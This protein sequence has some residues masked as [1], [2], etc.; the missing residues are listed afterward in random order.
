MPTDRPKF[1]L[2]TAIDYPNSRP[3]IGT[4]FEKIGADVQARYR[5]MQGYDVFFLMGNDENTVKVAKKA[6]ELGQDTQAYCDDMAR[7]FR[8]VWDALDISYDIFIQTSSPRHH[9]CCRKFIQKVYDNGYI[10]KDKYEGW[11]CVGCEAFKT[12]QEIKEAGGVCPNHKTSP[13]R[14]SEECYFFEQTKF[15]ERLL[16]LYKERPE[17]IQPE[18]RR[19]EIISLVKEG[20][21]D[22][23]ITRTGEEW[24]IRVPWDPK[25]TIYVWFDALLTY[26]TGI[27]YGDDEAEFR[28][29]WPCD[30]H[31]IGKDITRF[32]CATWPAMLLAAGVE[33]PKQVF[34]HGFV[35]IKNEE[36]GA[37]EKIS[38]SLGNVVEPMEIISKFSGEAFRYYFMRECPFPGDGEFSWQRFADVY[39]SELANNLGN[40][41]SRVV[42]L[43]SKNFGGT[44]PG[45]RKIDPDAILP[46]YQADLEGNRAS[47]DGSEALALIHPG[48]TANVIANLK[49]L[50]EQ[51]RYNQALQTI[52]A[53]FLTPANRFAEVTEPW[54]LVKTNKGNAAEVLKYMLVPLRTVSILLKPFVPRAAE[55]IYRSFNFT[56]PWEHVQYEDAAAYETQGDDLRILAQLEGGKVK[57]LFPRIG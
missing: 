27:G 53:N 3:H 46:Y 9:E 39:N 45:G 8:E 1:F 23:N 12:E 6:A 35:Y 18:S 34:G 51:C 57:P 32:H 50:V 52:W 20:L 17:L 48:S 56:K 40:L 26:I 5:R 31:F 14:R 42:T 10:R 36:T 44:L 24:G 30:I 22:L 15:R 2:T 28:K 49:S 29:W 11:Y 43:I 19:N 13:I 54:K 21:Y 25:F 47:P 16:K 37:A 38:K 33:P 4:A 7:Q 41:Y 55:T